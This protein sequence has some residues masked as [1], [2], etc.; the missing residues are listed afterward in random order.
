V[1]IDREINS[2]VD[3]FGSNPQALQKRYSMTKELV[4]LLALQKIKKSMDSARASV[5]AQMQTNPATIK[6]QRE[7]E[8]FGRTA[9]DVAQQVG[10]VLQ[11]RQRQ[12]KQGMQRMAQRAA[13]P[14]GLGALQQP[15]RMQAGGIVAFQ[16]G[17][18][19]GG[20]LG[21]SARIESERPERPDLL[22]E[23]SQEQIDEL[24]RRGLLPENFKGSVA[25]R[26]AEEMLAEPV[27]ETPV[28]EPVPAPEP[29]PEPAPVD[30]P[31]IP[32]AENAVV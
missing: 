27:S 30:E 9:Q 29:A 18:L 10:G 23:A 22:D 24:I 32:T 21:E 28:T 12:Q 8:I 25:R 4:D 6:Q 5:E 20:R 26:R 7:Q 16:E 1:S 15:K 2:R 11:N 19:V 31:K 14:Q 3:A 13:P 17:N